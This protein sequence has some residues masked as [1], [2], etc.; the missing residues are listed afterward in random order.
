MKLKTEPP[1][2]MDQFHKGG[3]SCH[4]Q[5]LERESGISAVTKKDKGKQTPPSI[6]TSLYKPALRTRGVCCHNT[7]TPLSLQSKFFTKRDNH[8]DKKTWSEHWKR[9]RNIPRSRSSRR[10]K[11]QLGYRTGQQTPSP[12]FTVGT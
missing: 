12:D 4:R 10:E 7:Y 3:M 8:H 5:S 9:W 2:N 1:D 11:R 6:H